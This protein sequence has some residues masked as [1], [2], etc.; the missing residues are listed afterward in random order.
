MMVPPVQAASRQH[1]S[2]RHAS[3]RETSDSATTLHARN[4]RATIIN[5]IM[6]QTRTR[7]I[8]GH[9]LIPRYGR[10]TI[11]RTGYVINGR[12]LRHLVNAI[13]LNVIIANNVRHRNTLSSRKTRTPEK[14]AH[15]SHSITASAHENARQAVNLLEYDTNTT[16]SY[17]ANREQ[18]AEPDTRDQQPH[19][20]STEPTTAAI[21][22]R[23][24]P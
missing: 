11:F 2:Q 7:L 21:L 14:G 17:P 22:R 23:Q 6:L 4:Q 16:V 5:T 19:Q 3:N 8:A 12:A 9:N 24:K 15:F 1:A 20:P 10:I 13:K 18:N